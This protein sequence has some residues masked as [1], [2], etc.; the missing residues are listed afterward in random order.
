MQFLQK[1]L[2]LLK[3]QDD[4]RKDARFMELSQIINQFL[5]E[6]NECRRRQL[7]LR[8]YSVVP[9][10]EASGLIE[11]VPNCG[12]FREMCISTYKSMGSRG[13]CDSH[14]YNHLIYVILARF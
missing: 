3:N 8:A 14:P 12:T 13:M 1:H 2:M 9:L 5:Q 6:D 11:W 7:R 10:N 4:L